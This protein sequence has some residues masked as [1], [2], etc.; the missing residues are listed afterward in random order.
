MDFFEQLKQECSLCARCGL[1]ATRTNLVFGTG[2]EHSDIVFVGEGPGEK[3]DL[4]G[5]PFV[6]PAGQLLDTMLKLIGLRRE[7]VYICNIV[8]CRPPHNR[9]PTPEEAEACKI[10]L[11]MQTYLV[12]PRVILL[13]G[14]TAAKG[15]LGDQVRITRD[16]GIWT[17]RKGVWIMPTYHPSALLRDPAKK[18]EA[19]EDLKQVRRKLTELGLYTD[20]LKEE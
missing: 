10:H 14:A 2:N 5:I 4:Q 8:K 9:I 7:D 19:W 1:G 15:V 6:G 13:L 20:L 18:S 12:R 16:R 17:E 11:R 3:E